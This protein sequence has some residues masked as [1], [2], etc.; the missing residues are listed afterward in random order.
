MIRQWK[1]DL[2]YAWHSKLF[3]GMLLFFFAS[4]LLIFFMND[5]QARGEYISYQH[6]LELY[7][8]NGSDI[9]AELEAGYTIIE[10]N[11]NSGTVQNPLAYHYAMLGAALYSMQPA[12]AVSLVCESALV[13]FPILA[14]FFGL[15]WVSSDQKHKT[16]RHRVQRLGKQKS[17]WCKQLSGFSLLLCLL[18]LTLPF[19]LCIQAWFRSRF[20]AACPLEPSE[21]TYT[22]SIT[23]HYW[24]QLLFAVVSLAFYYEFGYT[25]GHLLK[26]NPI[27]LVIVCVY[28]LFLPPL[29]RYD[30]CNVFNSFAN[31]IFE[32][33]G[34]FSLTAIPEIS[35]LWGSIELAILFV[36]MLLGNALLTKYRSAY[37]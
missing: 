14:S 35:L 32:F 10:D 28:V 29:F 31:G 16:L 15:I 9:E 36:L 13:F 26:G 8:E 34:P 37:V 24:K 25:F 20:M 3:A 30:I 18:I 33:A 6:S 1:T 12:Y 11:G 19:A 7:Q 21:F 23:A 4:A 27:S 22:S 5:Q 2:R 17:L